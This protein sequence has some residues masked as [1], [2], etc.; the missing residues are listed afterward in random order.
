MAIV[1]SDHG[2]LKKGRK[3]VS[4]AH[5]SCDCNADRN[6]AQAQ[7]QHKLEYI[8]GV[9]TQGHTDP[10]FMR[11]QRDSVSNDATDTGSDEQESN[12]REQ[13]GDL[14][15]ARRGDCGV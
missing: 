1:P 8:A 12:T 13:A 14:D 6:Q 5:R 3:P 15:L 4:C 7:A 2:R 9:R 11:S 10:N